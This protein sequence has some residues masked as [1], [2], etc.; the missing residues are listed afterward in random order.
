MRHSLRILLCC[1]VSVSLA[2]GCTSSKPQ[3]GSSPVKT[4]RGTSSASKPGGS[5]RIIGTA[6]TQKA[7]T[8]I[9]HDF[10]AAYPSVHVTTNFPPTTTYTTV[11]RTQLSGSNGADVLLAFPGGASAMSVIPLVKSNAIT[12]LSD[13]P[14]VSKVKDQWKGLVGVH[15]KTYMYPLGA[16]TMGLAYNKKVFAAKGITPPTTLSG[17]LDLCDK[18]NSKGIAPIAYGAKDVAF[19]VFNAL[20]PS[21]VYRTDPNF[22][23]ERLAGKTSF[24]SSPGWAEALQITLKLKD[25]KCFNNGFQGTGYADMLPMLASGKAAMSLTVP[26]SL[27][28]ITQADPSG[29][30][31]Y[32]PLPAYDDEAKNYAAEALAV[33]FAVNSRT[34]NATAAKAFVAFANQAAEAEK[35]AAALGDA[36]LE[37]GAT[38]PPALELMVAKWRQNKTGPFPEQSYPNAGVQS[39]EQAITQEVLTGQASIDKAL[40]K[41]DAAYDKK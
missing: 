16:D 35:F 28:T 13:Q 19:F 11:T 29:D 27:P 26:A 22:D 36:S 10:S 6:D 21:T 33:G 14:W 7:V 3:A 8:A 39:T 9:V 41:L 5:L 25:R 24:A 12:D 38:T 30:Y 31:A 17:L 23:T 20:L 37:Q 15:G 32:F 1:S 4:P 2:A 18:F 34:K 40:K